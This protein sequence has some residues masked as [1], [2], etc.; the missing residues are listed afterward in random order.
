LR[1]AFL[2]LSVA[3]ETFVADEDFIAIA[4]TLTG[5]QNGVFMGVAPTG[6]KMKVRGTQ[7]IKFRDG[8][9]VERWGSSDELGLLQQLGTIAASGL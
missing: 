1:V 6:R 9:M 3:L 8:M 7:M 2:D 5:T 4:C